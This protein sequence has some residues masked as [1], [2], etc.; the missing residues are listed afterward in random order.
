MLPWSLSPYLRWTVIISQKK[1]CGLAEMYH[2]HFN[3]S[4]V[5]L[6]FTKHFLMKWN[7]PAAEARIPGGENWLLGV[8]PI[9]VP[10][11]KSVLGNKKIR[12]TMLGEERY[13]T[14]I[15]EA[16]PLTWGVNSC[17]LIASWRSNMGATKQIRCL[18]KLITSCL[19]EG[20]K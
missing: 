10:I 11:C 18:F 4:T 16:E 15:A 13:L 5:E 17:Y 1:A 9:K 12:Q 19:V 2:L 6:N 7:Q 3:L 8:L 20:R 14:C